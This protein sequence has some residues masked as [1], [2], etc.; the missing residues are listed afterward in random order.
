MFEGIY[1]FP[2]YLSNHTICCLYGVC[3]GVNT[4]DLFGRN[5]II[6]YS[7]TYCCLGL[8]TC[9][10]QKDIYQL[11]EKTGI[12]NIDEW[13]SDTFYDNYIESY[14]CC[15]LKVNTSMHTRRPFS[16]EQQMMFYRDHFESHISFLYPL[17]KERGLV[18]IVLQYYPLE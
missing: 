5:N 11:E 17:F 12:H 6:R 18:E 4:T 16:P 14:Y 13:I 1:C 9:K 15:Y 10:I 8:W 7:E 2:C 3:C